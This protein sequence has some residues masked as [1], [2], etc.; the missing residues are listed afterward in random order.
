MNIYNRIKS[1]F[2]EMSFPP[3]V[4]FSGRWGGG[5]TYH[6]K[7]TI[8]PNLR[9][10]YSS[11]DVFYLSLYGISNLDEFRDKVI[12]NLFVDAERSTSKLL[13]QLATTIDGVFKSQGVGGISSVVTG[14]SGIYK[15]SVYDG[16][17]EKIF[18]FDDLERLKDKNLI[19]CILGEAYNLAEKNKVKILFIANDDELN[20]DDDV[21]KVFSD[22]ISYVMT[23]EEITDIICGIHKGLFDEGLK[24][25]LLALLRKLE[26][27]NIRVLKRAVIRF[28]DVN[29]RINQ[30][31]N[32]DVKHSK[33]ILLNHI[34]RF[35]YL[36]GEKKLTKNDLLDYSN[37]LPVNDKT[38]SQE[39][40]EKT[41][42]SFF[43]A[44]EC[45]L[46][47]CLTGEYKFV[48]IAKELSLPMNDSI[49]I[50]SHS[51]AKRLELSDDE[52]FEGV[53]KS[54]DIIR[55]TGDKVSL[56]MWVDVC[57]SLLEYLSFN[58]IPS[59]MITED[60]IFGMIDKITVDDFL[61]L[62]E[63]EF[64]YG[65]R[66]ISGCKNQMLYNK[67][68]DIYLIMKKKYSES[69]NMEIIDNLYL[70]WCDVAEL[71][72]INY[73]YKQFF[74]N[75]SVD[76]LMLSLFSNWSTKDVAYF[77]TFI[78]ERYEDDN[79]PKEEIDFVKKLNSKLAGELPN[80]D[81]SLRVYYLT[82]LNL[83]LEKFNI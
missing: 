71:V 26:I 67:F 46:D 18:I 7:N 80:V 61:V 6:I 62:T 5:K 83:G 9:K 60:E 69:K 77:C 64:S 20:L 1:V 3:V 29:E 24:A 38:A 72:E 17:N 14:L 76:K 8:I 79:Y 36:I 39:L 57:D 66:F 63:S 82:R 49:F 19:S 52:F 58:A 81:S 16:L 43:D 13:S 41:L 51:P 33:L 55:L 22:R 15:F 2:D 78:N 25:N 37:V 10:D 35:F 42:G 30:I 12:S 21:E 73:Q 48:D 32:L 11:Y 47:F 54:I 40:I 74:N 68:H 56:F 53:N 28:K 45:L 65:D 75:V 70:S 4:L 44:N 27:E 31:E 23:Y 34:V 59:K 50:K